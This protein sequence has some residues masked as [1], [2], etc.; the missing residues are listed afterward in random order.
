M[1]CTVLLLTNHIQSSVSLTIENA[2]ITIKRYIPSWSDLYDILRDSDTLIRRTVIELQLLQ[3]TSDWIYRL[4]N[5]M[6]IGDDYSLFLENSPRI[7]DEIVPTEWSYL[8]KCYEEH[9]SLRN[10]SSI[11]DVESIILVGIRNWILAELVRGIY[12]ANKIDDMKIAERWSLFRELHQKMNS[13]LLTLLI[14]VECNHIIL[15]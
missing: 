8:Q 1:D 10:T 12:S 5:L 3:R 7:N 15:V 2:Q 11:V 14:L 4:C 6:S 9:P 13:L